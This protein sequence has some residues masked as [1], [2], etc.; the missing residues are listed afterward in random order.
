MTCIIGFVDKDRVIIGGD[1]AGCTNNEISIRKDVKVFRKEDFLFGCSGSFRTTQLVRFCL[2]IPKIKKDIFE[3]LCI[4][5]VNNLRKCLNENGN[6][7]KYPEGD[8]K[9]PYFLIGYKNRL[10]GIESD[11]QVAENI[12]GIYCIGSGSEYA[13]GAMEVLKD[14]DIS[15]EE[16]VR[17]ALEASAIYS[18]G[19]A[20]PFIIENT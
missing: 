19:V 5:F 2:E 18:P 12:N 10:F 4:D 3:Y 6:G 15:A 17:K 20:G 9:G 1:S 7:R 11:Y 13:H 14:L 8:E 16:K